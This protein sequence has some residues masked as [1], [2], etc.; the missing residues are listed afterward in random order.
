M[1]G[2]FSA[3]SILAVILFRGLAAVNALSSRHRV[4][5]AGG[6]RL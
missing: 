1:P 4:L 3:R 2:S 5:A 6:L